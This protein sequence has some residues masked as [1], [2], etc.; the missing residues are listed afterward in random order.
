M[1]LE[2]QL[3]TGVTCEVEKFTGNQ[4][5][6]LTEQTDK[7]IALR[8]AELILSV[9]K[10][11]GNN[12][13]LSIAD[14]DNLLSE[15]RKYILVKA[16]EYTMAYD[17][18]FRIDYEYKSVSGEFLK[19]PVDFTIPEE[20]LPCKP[21]AQQVDDYSDIQREYQVTLPDS[22]VDC[23]FNLLDGHAEKRFGA[24]P[25]KQISAHTPLMMR[26][27]R[28]LHKDGGSTIPIQANFDKMSMQDLT[29]L[30]KEI[31]KVEGEVLTTIK[32]DHPEADSR[33]DKERIV[34]VDMLN[35]VGFFFPSGAI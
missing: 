22:G 17:P 12:I 16:R 20:G 15:D 29:F 26:N 23:L 30:R 11:I 31:E 35:E 13:H 21:Y 19:H 25:K 28:T 32:F 6:I 4:Q 33:P 3:L 5:R 8:M 7:P 34:T 2:F 24:I 27:V 14:I 10:R 18:I 9:T 1:S